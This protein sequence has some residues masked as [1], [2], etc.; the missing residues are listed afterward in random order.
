MSGASRHNSRAARKAGTARLQHAVDGLRQ[1][2]ERMRK[3]TSLADAKTGAAQQAVRAM[4][5]QRHADGALLA[6]AERLMKM[7]DRYHVANPN[8]A[9]LSRSA[10]RGAEEVGRFLMHMREP[11]RARQLRDRATMTVQTLHET[12]HMLRVK[13]VHE[14][15]LRRVHVRV[16]LGRAQAGYAISESALLDMDDDELI[17]QLAPEIARVLVHDVRRAQRQWP[18]NLHDFDSHDR[19]LRRF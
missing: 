4:E 14:A 5:Q 17:E 6:A 19:E 8:L 10:T 1:H 12:M 15:L 16:D 9:I 7:V 13:T 18:R 11:I 2:N 3:R